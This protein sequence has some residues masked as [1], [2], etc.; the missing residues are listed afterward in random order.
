MFTVPPPLLPDQSR[1]CLLCLLHCCLIGLI[2]LYSAAQDAWLE[3]QIGPEEFAKRCVRSKR[4]LMGLLD[5]PGH[6]NLMEIP[7]EQVLLALTTDVDKETDDSDFCV[8]NYV[9][10]QM[11]AKGA[12]RL[13]CWLLFLTCLS[14]RPHTH[15]PK[16]RD[17]PLHQV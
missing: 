5:I 3:E 2:C 13:H 14:C 17:C 7:Y 4:E 10:T 1:P 9:L 15:S 16:R 6:S 8:C 12:I 11:N